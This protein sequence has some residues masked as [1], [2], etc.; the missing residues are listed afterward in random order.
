MEQLIAAVAPWFLFAVVVALGAMLI[1]QRL[2]TARLRRH[3]VV[4]EHGLRDR[5]DEARHLV[6]TRLPV[7]TDP[8]YYRPA[9]LPGLLHPDLGGTEYAQSLEQVTVMFAESSDKALA[10]A[11]KSAQAALKAVMKTVQSLAK[12][13]QL[14]ISTMQDEHDDPGVLE[15]LLE[16][17]HANSQLSRRAQAIAVLCGSWAGQRRSAAALTD[18]V[19]GA[20]SRIR[21]YLRVRVH[22]TTDTAVGGW[23]VEPVVLTLAELLDNAA[24]YSPPTTTV[25]VNFH[26]AHNGTAIVVDDAGIGMGAEARELATAVLSGRRQTVDI[27]ALGDPP[28]V[29]FA[30][31]G[32]LSARYGFSVSIDTVSPYGGVRA[33]VFLPNELLTSVEAPAAEAQIPEVSSEGPEAEEL[34]VQRSTDSGLPKRRRRQRASEPSAAQQELPARFA[35]HA[36]AGLGA[37][38]RGTRSGRNT[39]PSDSEGYRQE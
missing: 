17:D 1:R 15:G 32:V 33:V 35:G 11:D 8:L 21:H 23:V 9:E 26:P 30:V 39:T 13:Q 16:I 22:E 28:Q 29:G 6:T 34:A 31:I 24:R 27:T 38:Q 7:L 14:A 25:E 10:R 2:M 19:R 37:W 4:L 36:A 18:V 3:N 5:E 12:E 20:T